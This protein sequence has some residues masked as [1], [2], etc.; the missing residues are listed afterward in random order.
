MEGKIDGK[1]ISVEVGILPTDGFCLKPTSRED[2]H[3]IPS[4]TKPLNTGNRANGRLI[5]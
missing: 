2:G 4:E 1:R 3:E 5:V